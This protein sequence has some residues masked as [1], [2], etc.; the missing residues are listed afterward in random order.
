MLPIMIP[1]SDIPY[2]SALGRFLRWWLRWIPSGVVVP[3]LQGPLRGAR[4]I[5]GAQTH[6]MWLG[7][8][9]SRMQQVLVSLL[10]AG[11]IFYDVGANVG[12]YSLL[13]ARQVGA[14]GHVYAFEPLPRNIE[15][16]DRH[17]HLNKCTNVTIVPCAV[18]NYVGRA[19]FKLLDSSTSHLSEEGELEVETITL[20]DFVFHRY[21]PSPKIIKV[22]V[23]G[24]E[25][26]VLRGATRCLME[27]RPFVL[28]SVHS[29]RLYA[30]VYKL[31]LEWGYSIKTLQ[32]NAAQPEFYTSELI[33]VPKEY[34]QINSS[35]LCVDNVRC[36]PGLRR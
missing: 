11:D 13:A 1:F 16:L 33:L 5:V 6:G 10:K 19:R 8:Y 30:G 31:S 9:E 3:V 18:I 15:Y 17:I 24:A 14:Q 27:C 36:I 34:D 28:I 32:W 20:D 4:W 2:S 7:S 12:F 22:D 21:S 25:I 26:E 29:A 23:E 35:S